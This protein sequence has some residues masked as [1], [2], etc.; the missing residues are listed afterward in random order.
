MLVQMKIICVGK[1]K[2]NYWK[3]A[4]LEYQK[5][6]LKYTKIEW[7]ELPDSSF[8]EEE[9][10]KET[11]GERILQQIKEKDYVV[12]CEIDGKEMDSLSFAEHLEKVENRGPLVFVIGGS[13]GLSCKVKERRNEAI[14]F[15]KLT[16][17]HQLFRVLLLE[18][19][20]RSYKIRNHETYHK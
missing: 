10:N 12:T 9:K 3:D 2:E 7:I 14:S 19:I 5:R 6:L 18:Q 16:F 8:N 17:P 1:L 20:Y 4:V 15:S 11:E 13:N